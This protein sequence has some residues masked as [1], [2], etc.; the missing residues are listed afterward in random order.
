MIEF[1]KASEIRR[2]YMTAVF[3]GAPNVGKTSLALTASRPAILDF[4]GNIEVAENRTDD[5]RAIQ[6]TEWPQIA[7][8]E[9]SD[10]DGCD[11]VIIDTV[12]S[13]IEILLSEVLKDPKMRTRTGGPQRDAWQALSRDFSVWIGKLKAVGLN[14]IMTAHSAEEQRGDDT[15]ERIDVIGKTKQLVYRTA[16]IMG[17]LYV[18]ADGKRIIDFDTRMGT[19]RK[20]CGLAPVVVKHPFLAPD[21]AARIIAEALVRINEQS[22]R[23]SDEAKRLTDVTVHVNA[24][25]TVDE[26]NAETHSMAHGEV[27]AP[28]AEKK[29]L[30]DRARAIGLHYYRD[31]EL[32]LPSNE[33]AERVRRGAEII[34]SQHP[35][36]PAQNAT[37]PAPEPAPVPAPTEAPPEPSPPAQEPPAATTAK[38]DPFPNRTPAPGLPDA[39]P[40]SAAKPPPV[41]SDDDYKSQ[42]I[43]MELF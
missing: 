23:G 36:V 12:G 6:V 10:F 30:A 43:E 38:V 34:A 29:I 31:L 3:Y 33:E 26:I 5:I 14:V 7:N 22:A 24:L 19:F 35:S 2:K 37:Q 13:A 32:W 16:Q 41:P 11:T 39:P 28:A 21:T 20:N 40:P 15:V 17:T 18:D 1:R 9:A 42:P 4:D 8:P 27:P 25:S